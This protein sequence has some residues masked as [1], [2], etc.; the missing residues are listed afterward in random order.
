MYLQL[1]VQSCAAV[2]GSTPGGAVSATV[3]GRARSVTYLPPSVSI[4]NVGDTDYA[5]RVTVC[6]TLATKEPTVNKVNERKTQHLPIGFAAARWNIFLCEAQ[7]GS[8]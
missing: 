8:T 2:T 3:A 5:W 6:A 1:L 7:G 4:L